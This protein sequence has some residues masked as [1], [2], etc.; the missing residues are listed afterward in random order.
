VRVVER[1]VWK[2]ASVNK[3]PASVNTS[4]REKKKRIVKCLV[5]V[6]KNFKGPLKNNSKKI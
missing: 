6:F 5:W 1:R 3:K 2:V 4:Y